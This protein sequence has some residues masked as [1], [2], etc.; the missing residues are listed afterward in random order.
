M[1]EEEIEIESL[2]QRLH[3][4]LHPTPPRHGDSME[5]R[6]AVLESR[7]AHGTM[8]CGTPVA[9]VDVDRVLCCC[10]FLSSHIPGVFLFLSPGWSHLPLHLSPALLRL[11]TLR[12]LSAIRGRLHRSRSLPA[13]EQQLAAKTHDARLLADENTFLRALTERR[14]GDMEARQTLA[15]Q[16]Q[17]RGQTEARAE[18]RVLEA[19]IL[20][21]HQKVATVTTAVNALV[22]G[23]AVAKVLDRVQHMVSSCNAE[24]DSLC[25]AVDAI[26]VQQN[27][28]R[29]A[30]D[31]VELI[32]S[33]QLRGG[34]GGPD[35]S[36]VVARRTTASSSFHTTPR[37]ASPP[38]RRYT[39]YRLE[40]AMSSTGVNELL[41]ALKTYSDGV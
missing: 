15:E 2:R 38:P 22:K 13:V 7:L 36:A 37:A 19:A 1:S 11:S 6:F 8:R 39:P 3:T 14:L 23:G 41:A 18:A 16:T 31:S 40:Q 5:R 33:S 30:L 27:A 26:Q 24:I 17:A 4:R 29:R 21:V 35:A 25:Q 10:C 32:Q 9:L 28:L 12:S 20:D 34:G